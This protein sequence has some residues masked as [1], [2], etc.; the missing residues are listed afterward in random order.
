MIPDGAQMPRTNSGRSMLADLWEPEYEGEGWRRNICD[1]ED[2]ARKLSL[3]DH[4][5][6]HVDFG[7][8]TLALTAEVAKWQERAEQAE[9]DFADA[10]GAAVLRAEA[11]ETQLERERSA[12]SEAGHEYHA[13]LRAGHVDDVLAQIRVEELAERVREEQRPWDRE[14]L[15]AVRPEMRRYL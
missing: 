1:I 14:E 9:A 7:V 2:E 5:K 15:L 12:F 3:L 11:A 6:A 10:V 13:C 8:T 4:A